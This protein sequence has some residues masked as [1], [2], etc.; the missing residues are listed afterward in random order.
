MT[1]RVLCGA[2]ALGPCLVL[3][4]LFCI[5]TRNRW[6]ADDETGRCWGLCFE[7]FSWAQTEMV[8]LLLRNYSKQY[9]CW[10]IFLSLALPCPPHPG[11]ISDRFYSPFSLAAFSWLELSSH[12]SCHS[13]QMSLCPLIRSTC[14]S[15]S[16]HIQVFRQI[17]LKI[18]MTLPD[19]RLNFISFSV[20]PSLGSG[21]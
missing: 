14:L 3:C 15:F 4:Y 5:V 10:C 1:V 2:S 16:L 19:V 13:S 20:S 11:I 8:Y 21:G 17:A 12:F 9:I 18:S 7:S 6:K